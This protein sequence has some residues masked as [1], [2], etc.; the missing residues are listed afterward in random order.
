MSLSVSFVCGRLRD[1]MDA[2][3]DQHRPPHTM[4]ASPPL[5]LSLFVSFVC[6]FVTIGTLTL[7]S[8]DRYTHHHPSVSLF[9]AAFFSAS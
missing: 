5:C 9:V 7:I 4:H 8:I 3:A 2:D 6:G 1:H